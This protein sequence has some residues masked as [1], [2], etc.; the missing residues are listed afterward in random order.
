LKD[1]ARR[2]SPE[3]IYR[4]I[5]GQLRNWSLQLGNAIREEKHIYI[6]SYPSKIDNHAAIFIASKIAT[7]TANLS[8]SLNGNIEQE[9]DDSFLVN[10][11]TEAQSENRISI[12]REN[13]LY[14]T[15]Y[16]AL[17][18]AEELTIIRDKE[19]A[20]VYSSVYQQA[21]ILDEKDPMLGDSR[22]V[23]SLK[24]YRKFPAI[25]GAATK[26]IA[27]ALHQT[28]NPYYPS[29]TGKPLDQIIDDLSRLGVEPEKS[30]AEQ[31]QDAMKK[32]VEKLLMEVRTYDPKAEAR[33]IAATTLI[34]NIELSLIHISSPRD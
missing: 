5:D 28:I 14:T 26:P 9:T 32:L 13:S 12:T 29:Y 17:L 23:G 2:L 21:R 34:A 7:K 31:S 1:G 4:L 30:F 25:T 6:S 15:A 16:T 18:L 8:L 33:R 20:T 10:I 22:V 3:G 19:R 24:V 11:G 27:Q